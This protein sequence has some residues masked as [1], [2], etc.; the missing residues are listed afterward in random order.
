ML[1][2][3]VAHVAAN[4]LRGIVELQLPDHW[5]N[6]ATKALFYSVSDCVLTTVYDMQIK[7]FI[8]LRVTEDCTGAY[9][10]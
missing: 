10:Q 8:V 4:F 2:T 1:C 3:C 7:V 6:K 9:V 5:T